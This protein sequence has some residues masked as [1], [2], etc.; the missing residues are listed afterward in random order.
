LDFGRRG[1]DA[2][3]RR[4]DRALMASYALGPDYAP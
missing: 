2:A 4:P 1:G 3:R